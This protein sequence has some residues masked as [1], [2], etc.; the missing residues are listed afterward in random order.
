MI[1]STKEKQEKHKDA[2]K[3][4]KAIKTEI[5]EIVFFH[6]ERE[7]STPCERWNNIGIMNV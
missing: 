3:D 1:C 2:E 6:L 4:A 7:Y 5:I